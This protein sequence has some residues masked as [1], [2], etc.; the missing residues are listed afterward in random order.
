MIYQLLLIYIHIEG[1][2][3]SKNSDFSFR[4]SLFSAFFLKLSRYLMVI[5]VF[6]HRSSRITTA[7][8]TILPRATMRLK[9]LYQSTSFSFRNKECATWTS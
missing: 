5:L 7:I 9:R 2:R 3:D 4:K 8:A 1:K 6:R